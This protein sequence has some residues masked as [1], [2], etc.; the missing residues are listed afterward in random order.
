[1]KRRPPVASPPGLIEPPLSPLGGP[2]RDPYC[3]PASQVTAVSR[4]RSGDGSRCNCSPAIMRAAVV[5]VREPSAA[6]RNCTRSLAL[7]SFRRHVA[8]GACALMGRAVRARDV[9]ADSYCLS[10]A[11]A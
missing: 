7:R 3:S 8:M 9:T 5:R 6:R 2:G 11:C 1:M 4:S 10:T